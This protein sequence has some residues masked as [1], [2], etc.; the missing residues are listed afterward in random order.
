MSLTLTFVGKCIES[1]EPGPASRTGI[2]QEDGT[3]Y[4]LLEDESY[5]LLES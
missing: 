3:S 5:L 1:E 4:L 2:L